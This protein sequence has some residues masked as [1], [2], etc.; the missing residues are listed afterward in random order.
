M[1]SSAY[2]GSP[3]FQTT[4][5]SLVAAAGNGEPVEARAALE[6]LCRGYW[7][8]VYA[9]IRRR[10]YQ[11]DDARDLTQEFFARLIEKEH[12]EAADQQRG[13]FRTFL[14]TAVT[15]FLANQQERAAA[16]KRGGG[17]HPL[18]LNVSDGESRYQC[19]P[20]DH[21]TAERLF[22][23]RWALT[24]LDRTLASLRAEN[25]ATGKAAHFDALKVYLTGESGAPSLRQTASR[26]QMTE[27]AVKVAIHRLRQK[28]RDVLRQEVSQTV[29][30]DDEVENELRLLLSALR[31]GSN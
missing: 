10:G 1:S 14:L 18:S 7:Y 20:A 21:W 4:Q 17:Q 5:W 31:G 3:R 16:Q 24:L 15:R 23:R 22:D 11:P 19:E 27:G 28:Y 12:L 8:P 2:S 6:Q 13:R 26:L 9:F 29:S 30:G 25:E